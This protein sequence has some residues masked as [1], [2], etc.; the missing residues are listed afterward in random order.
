[1]DLVTG[2][3]AALLRRRTRE[4]QAESG[5]V[6]ITVFE[7]GTAFTTRRYTRYAYR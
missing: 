7:F 4:L 5:A 2:D 6:P 3:N 1:M